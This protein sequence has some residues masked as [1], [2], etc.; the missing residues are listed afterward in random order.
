[1][2]DHRVPQPVPAVCRHGARLDRFCAA[3]APDPVRPE[4]TDEFEGWGDRLTIGPAEGVSCACWRCDWR[5]DDGS[6]HMQVGYI[7]EPLRVRPGW[8]LVAALASFAAGLLL[9]RLA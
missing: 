7:D 9:G 5:E 8:L 1:M 3:C 2:T 6:L 4:G